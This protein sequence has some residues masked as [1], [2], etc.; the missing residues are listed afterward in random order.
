MIDIDTVCKKLHETYAQRKG[1]WDGYKA[2]EQLPRVAS[3]Q[4]LA[5]MEVLVDAFNH[6]LDKVREEI[7]DVYRHLDD[8]R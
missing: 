4:V 1:C 3:D 6:E 2:P 8:Q 5:L 7:A